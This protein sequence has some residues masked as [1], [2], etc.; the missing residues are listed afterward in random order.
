MYE[1]MNICV[2]F[3]HKSQQQ[4]LLPHK[5][6]KNKNEIKEEAKLKHNRIM[7]NRPPLLFVLYL[8]R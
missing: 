5:N 7:T 2:L 3:N 8:S 4:T 1:Q 6:S